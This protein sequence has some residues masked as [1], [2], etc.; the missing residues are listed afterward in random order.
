MSKRIF[1]INTILIIIENLKNEVKF[2]YNYIEFLNIVIQIVIFVVIGIGLI[3]ILIAY[4]LEK[5]I[6]KLEKR[7]KELEDYIKT[8]IKEK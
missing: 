1:F 5:R 4:A 2:T 6:K 8:S 3:I 7:I